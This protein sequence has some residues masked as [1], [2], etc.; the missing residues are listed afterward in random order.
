ML[1]SPGSTLKDIAAKTL[2]NRFL[3]APANRTSGFDF[4]RARR[5]PRFDASHY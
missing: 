2:H 3:H 4:S 5:L 1:A